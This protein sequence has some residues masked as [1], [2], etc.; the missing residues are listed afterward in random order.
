V[1]ENNG[2]VDKYIGDAIMAF[3]GA[4]MDNANHAI[5]SCTTAI[6][7]KRKMMEFSDECK[8]KGL[9]EIKIGMGINTGDMVVGNMGSNKRFDY[10]VIGDNVNLASRLESLTKQYHIGIN[11]SQTTF[12]MIKGKGFAARELDFVAVKGK[13]KPVKIYELVGFEND[14]TKKEKD[15]IAHFE[16]GVKHYFS[17]EFKEALKAFEECKEKYDDETSD[18]YIERCKEFI[19]NAPPKDWDGVFVAKTK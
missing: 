5:D 12:D 18:V 4:P 16:K 13:S 15:L 3:W 2:L 11:I 6:K 7:M 10:T 14:I 19:K 8:K 9:P 17:K 1:L